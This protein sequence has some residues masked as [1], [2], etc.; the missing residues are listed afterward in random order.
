MTMRYG[1][2]ISTCAVLAAAGCGGGGGALTEN[3]KPE[4][5]SAEMEPPEAALRGALARIDAAMIDLQGAAQVAG[6]EREADFAAVRDELADRQSEIALILGRWK[7]AAAE[8]RLRMA[9]P[10]GKVVGHVDATT[11]RI[12]ET[13]RQTDADETGGEI[14]SP[15]P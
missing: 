11:A 5:T 4:A 15:A 14:Q 12:A 6:A 3:A 9:D 13:S 1:F 2:L 7:Q 10:I 8:D